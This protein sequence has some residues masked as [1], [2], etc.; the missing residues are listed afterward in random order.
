MSV[1]EIFALIIL[2]LLLYGLYLEI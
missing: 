1:I 2:F